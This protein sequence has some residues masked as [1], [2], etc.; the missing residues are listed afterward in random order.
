[1]S[2]SV[3]FGNGAWHEGATSPSTAEPTAPSDSIRIGGIVT[4][5]DASTGQV[6]Q[7]GCSSMQ[8][9]HDSG[10][11]GGSVAATLRTST[12]NPSVEL[13]PGNPA[14]RTSVQVAMREGLIRQDPLTGQWLDAVP[15]VAPEA[16][17]EQPGQTTEQD[18][19]DD[20]RDDGAA[21]F[22]PE[23]QSLWAQ[24]IEPLPQGTYDAAVGRAI[25]VAVGTGDPARLVTELAQGAGISP[26]LAQDYVTQG[27]AMYE[28]VAERALAPILATPE[29]RSE[30][31]ESFRKDPGR[32]AD[33]LRYMVQGGDTRPLLDLARAFAATRR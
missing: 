25:S 24:D 14:S 8:F 20:R 15:F 29:L 17:E 13:I 11:A 23:D 21:A 12:G 19:Q 32:A 22:D 7:Q 5:T 28:R 18:Q 27:V 31:R 1:M 30:F 3:H 6:V 10:T 2:I 4:R 9:G 16:A 33:A 26:E